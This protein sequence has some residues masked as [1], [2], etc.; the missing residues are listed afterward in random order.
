M[1]LV[2]MLCIA[3]W[4]GVCLLLTGCEQRVL[5]TT[6]GRTVWIDTEAI[7]ARGLDPDKIALHEAGHISGYDHCSDRRCLMYFEAGP[8][9]TELCGNCR[10]DTFIWLKKTWGL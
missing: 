4:I 2:T 8:A 1:I 6:D 7:E 10:P 3:F 9:R 5:G